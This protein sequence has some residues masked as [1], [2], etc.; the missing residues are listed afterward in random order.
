MALSG[1]ISLPSP[2]EMTNSV[3]D[4][5]AKLEASGKTKRFTH[6]MAISQYDYDNWLAEQTGSAAVE[7]WRINIYR[8]TSTNKR[9]NPETYRDVW[10]DEDLHQEAYACLE[11]ID[12][13]DR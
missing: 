4:F 6:N 8:A 3:Q 9:Q 7:T 13:S 11:K 10:P 2:Q 1:K 12:L 5:Y